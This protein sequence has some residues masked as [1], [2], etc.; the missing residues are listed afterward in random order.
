MN[1]YKKGFYILR[2]HV[3]EEREPLNQNEDMNALNQNEDMNPL[4]QNEDMNPNDVEMNILSSDLSEKGS[5]HF[6]FSP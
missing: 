1:P 5:N 4:N 2:D 3:N 6:I